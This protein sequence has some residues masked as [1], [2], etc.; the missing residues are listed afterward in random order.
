MCGDVGEKATLAQLVGQPAWGVGLAAVTRVLGRQLGHA[1]GA[2]AGWFAVAA[3]AALVQ[4]ELRVGLGWQGDQPKKEQEGQEAQGH[5]AM[6]PP[7]P[8]AC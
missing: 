2:A 7:R 8:P 6:V 3:V 1:G 5:A 4:R